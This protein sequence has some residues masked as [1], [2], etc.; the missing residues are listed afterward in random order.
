MLNNVQ[1]QFLDA[2]QP[3]K[4]ISEHQDLLVENAKKLAVTDEKLALEGTILKFWAV[5]EG[6]KAN[7]SVK[8][9]GALDLKNIWIPSAAGGQHPV[10]ILLLPDYAKVLIEIVDIDAN[11]A[12]HTYRTS[13]GALNGKDENTLEHF[14]HLT[15]FVASRANFHDNYGM[16]YGIIFVCCRKKTRIEIR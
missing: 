8:Q 14:R 10:P 5:I 12:K 4:I 3:E 13:Q 2:Y 9:E 7:E 1:Y 15:M 6:A 16:Q 11:K